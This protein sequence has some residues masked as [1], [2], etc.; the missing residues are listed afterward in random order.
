MDPK[1]CLDYFGWSHLCNTLTIAS[2]CPPINTTHT[3]HPRMKWSSVNVYRNKDQLI[4]TGTH[5]KPQKPSPAKWHRA[6]SVETF[7]RSIKIIEFTE[8]R[9]TSA[10]TGDEDGKKSKNQIEDPQNHI[11]ASCAEEQN[12]FDRP[13]K[14]HW[15]L[16]SRTT[17]FL[18]WWRARVQWI[19]DPKMRVIMSVQGTKNG[20]VD[21]HL[22][23]RCLYPCVRDKSCTCVAGSIQKLSRQT[24]DLTTQ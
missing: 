14:V 1:V 4:N 7:A 22:T 24:I 20:S 21:P 5:N 17:S 18:G 9:V 11:T 13:C 10:V 12:Y 6:S 19:Q 23:N 3:R 15:F 16:S 2:A 8:T